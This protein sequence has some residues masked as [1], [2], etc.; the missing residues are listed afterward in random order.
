M[1]MEYR[2]VRCK[3]N[4]DKFI[5]IFNNCEIFNNKILIKDNLYNCISFIKENYH[6][7]ILKEIIAIHTPDNFVE[8]NYHLYSSIDEENLYITYI[9]DN[10]AESVS[11]IF[12]SAIADENE[13]F[14]L[15][16]IN[17]LNNKNLKRLYMPENWKG[18][19]LRKDYVQDKL[20]LRENDSNN[21]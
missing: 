5:E 7:D 11:E 1:L 20:G 3:M 2:F 12:P 4:W 6:Y 10:S 9:T 18:H 14:D 16:G 19:P 13:I 17:F 8:L 21:T 15:F